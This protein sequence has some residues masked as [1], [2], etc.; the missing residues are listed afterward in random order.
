MP[1]EH[2]QMSL[3]L[4]FATLWSNSMSTLLLVSSV[5]IKSIFGIFIYSVHSGTFLYNTCS[6]FQLWLFKQ[7]PFS[8]DVK[9]ND[10]GTRIIASRLLIQAVNISD[11]NGEKE[12]VRALRNVCHQSS[13]NVSV[14]H[15]YFVFFDQVNK[16]YKH[17]PILGVLSVYMYQE[18]GCVMWQY[19]IILKILYLRRKMLIQNGFF[20]FYTINKHFYMISEFFM[21]DNYTKVSEKEHHYGRA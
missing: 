4:C 20:T 15:P 11:T 17:C 5:P 18:L 6:S 12:M 21:P 16:V 14:F 8:L 2:F 13:L 1:Y 10:D 9:F 7:N 19:L 3:D